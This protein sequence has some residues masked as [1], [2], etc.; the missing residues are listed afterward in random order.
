MKFLRSFL[1]YWNESGVLISLLLIAGHFGASAQLGWIPF[2]IKFLIGIGAIVLSVSIAKA[3]SQSE[4]VGFEA[5][6]VVPSS[7]LVYGSLFFAGMI[8]FLLVGG[9][10]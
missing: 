7:A 3:S 2:F 1:Q 5:V 10:I 6:E 4:E 9:A 8:F